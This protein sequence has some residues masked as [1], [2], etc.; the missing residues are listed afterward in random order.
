M[1]CGE[2]FL[3][4]NCSGT[5]DFKVGSV[6]VLLGGLRM[7]AVME[8]DNE[9]V[10]GQIVFGFKI[11]VGYVLVRTLRCPKTFTTFTGLVRVTL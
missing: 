9:G 7:R 6:S 8:N 1:P 10:L 5:L 3:V 11:C 4:G 2:A